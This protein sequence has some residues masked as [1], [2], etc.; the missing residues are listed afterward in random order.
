MEPRTPCLVPPL[1]TLSPPRTLVFPSPLSL[2]SL[3]IAGNWEVP[4]P[5]PFSCCFA[6]R[7]REAAKFLKL[8]P[9]FGGSG[10]SPWNVGLGR[11]DIPEEKVLP[12]PS[13]G[14]RTRSRLLESAAGTGAL[15]PQLI[16]PTQGPFPARNHPKKDAWE[17]G[18]V[19]LLCKGG[20]DTKAPSDLRE[21]DLGSGVWLLPAWDGQWKSCLGCS[22]RRGG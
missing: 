4:F 9:H 17:K 11:E 21:G 15:L 5:P 14:F 6:G 1:P 22:A 3:F 7:G 8:S 13:G 10:V 20:S 12:Q 2:W 18:D 16:P 19:E